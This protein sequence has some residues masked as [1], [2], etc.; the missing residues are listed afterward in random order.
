VVG[1]HVSIA[2]LT[3]FKTLDRHKLVGRL[4]TLEALELGTARFLSDG[5]CV[6]FDAGEPLVTPVRANGNLQDDEDHALA[7]SG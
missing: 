5:R 6:A 3:G 2:C 7:S 1:L 4:D